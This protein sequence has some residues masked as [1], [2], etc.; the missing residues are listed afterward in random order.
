MVT[1]GF[2]ERMLERIASAMGM[3]VAEQQ[4]YQ[5]DYMAELNERLEKQM[6]DQRM[7]PDVLAKRCTL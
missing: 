1:D 6:A 7:T 3:T 4:Q 5:K 2:Y